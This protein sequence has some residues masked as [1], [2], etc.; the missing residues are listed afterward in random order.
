MKTNKEVLEYL[1]PYTEMK[2]V[3]L[4]TLVVVHPNIMEYMWVYIDIKSSWKGIGGTDTRHQ[5][6]K[7]YLKKNGFRYDER[8]LCYFR[9]VHKKYWK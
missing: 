8:G 5:T 3:Y 6:I 2:G 7:Q 1:K 9:P 4:D